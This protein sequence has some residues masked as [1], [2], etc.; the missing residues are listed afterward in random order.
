MSHDIDMGSG[1]IL[2]VKQESNNGSKF[3]MVIKR[4]EDTNADEE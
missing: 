2:D 1:M 3:P 4:I